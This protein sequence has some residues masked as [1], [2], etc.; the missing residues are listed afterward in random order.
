M[1]LAKLKQ[2]YHFFDLDLFPIV[3]RRPAKQTEIIAHSFGHVPAFDVSVE[4]RA[5]IALAHL[6]SVPVQNE[7]D[8]GE[9]GRRGAQRTVELNMLGRV[10][11]MILTANDV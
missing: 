11:K 5:L 10:R 2:P 3:L 6:R 1:N 7:R 4:T 8:V 9:T